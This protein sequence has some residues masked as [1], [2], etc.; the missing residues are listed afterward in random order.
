M[1]VDW[2][3]A[4]RDPLELFFETEARHADL[5]TPDPNA[6]LIACALPAWRAGERRIA[7]EGRAC[8]ILARNLEVVCARIAMWFPGEL[9]P[10][11]VVE[12][13]DGF[14][15]LDP[16]DGKSIALVSSGIDS[17]ASV[18]WNMLN[19]P[20]SHERSIGALMWIGFDPHNEP[21][22]ARL[23]DATQ[24]RRPAVEAVAA[25]VGAELVPIRTNSWWLVD[26]GHFFDEKWHG[27]AYSSAAAF[28]SSRFR[29]VYVAA[30]QDPWVD[31]PWGSHPMLDPYY[32]S[33]HLAI[34]HDLMISRF[35]KTSLVGSWPVGR[36][37]IRVCQN[38]PS[39]S[40][41]CGT[42]EKCI[43]TSLMLLSQG[44]LRSSALP[45]DVTPHVVALLDEYQMIS[46]LAG[47]IEYYDALVPRLHAIARHDLADALEVVLASTRRRYGAVS[48]ATTV[49]TN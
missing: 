31:V 2:E 24:G 39:G 4:K 34:E 48:K 44:Q 22:S 7:L 8:P 41:N 35:D 30:G 9:G 40:R 28:F 36:D 46:P 6:A 20:P 21:S 37:A 26:D 32:S 10:P 15:A 18:R 49:N 16:V 42:C 43:R 13:S 47:F 19:V 25:E 3:D 23:R 38:D 12:A 17:L 1:R 33:A 11:P 27:A 45:R 5:V 14:K 29:R